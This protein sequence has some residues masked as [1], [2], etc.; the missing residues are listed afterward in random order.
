MF[1][2]KPVLEHTQDILTRSAQTIMSKHMRDQKVREVKSE[3]R[4]PMWLKHSHSF[5]DVQHVLVFSNIPL[6]LCF[7]FE[8]IFKIDN[9][10]P[11]Q[12]VSGL[13]VT[14]VLVSLPSTH[15]KPWCGRL[16]EMRNLVDPLQLSSMFHKSS[17][18]MYCKGLGNDDSFGTYN[19]SLG[20][21]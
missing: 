15:E 2:I 8:H 4:D 17:T 9:N 14:C 10:T 7:L 18:S 1:Q 6:L 21:A 13:D 5:S 12:I 19:C 20:M 3:K 16:F 11:G